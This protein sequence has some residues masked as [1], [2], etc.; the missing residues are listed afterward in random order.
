MYQEYLSEIDKVPLFSVGEIILLVL[1]ASVVLLLFVFFLHEGTF[2]AGH[3]SFQAFILVFLFCIGIVVLSTLKQNYAINHI[4]ESYKKKVPI[5]WVTKSEEDLYSMDV[6]D[7]YE[8]QG[9]GGIFLNQI[10]SKDF[11]DYR[12]VVKTENG[13]QLRTLS[14]Q[15]SGVS[16]EDIYIQEK[17]ETVS[18]KII[19]E[20]HQYKEKEFNKVFDADEKRVIFVVPEGT[21]QTKFEEGVIK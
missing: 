18:P 13:Y 7:K 19:L 16:E 11:T 1:C 6:Q 8:L 12:Y 4:K 14:K 10:S 15:Y 2:Y 21:V 3:F 17:P 5:E 20:Q 9:S